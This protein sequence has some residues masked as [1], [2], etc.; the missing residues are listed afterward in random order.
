M[1]SPKQVI[2]RNSEQSNQTGTVNQSDSTDNMVI[3]EESSRQS[4]NGAESVQLTP[5]GAIGV[6]TNGQSGAGSPENFGS[7]GGNVANDQGSGPPP[8][9][10]QICILG[11]S[12]GAANL[13]K[14]QA[15]T[16][17]SGESK[18]LVL[19]SD[20][21]KVTRHS[22]KSDT[23]GESWSWRFRRLFWSWFCFWF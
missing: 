11:G 19:S 14:A 18:V 1:T 22:A 17:G 2:Q 5:S 3:V 23:S 13:P 20:D 8:A 7:P 15:G 16:G 12:T 10:A 9:Q 4:D 6:Q 21:S